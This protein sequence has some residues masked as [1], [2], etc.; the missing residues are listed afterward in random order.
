M[1][2]TILVGL[3]LAIFAVIMY[4]TYKVKV[5]H[6]FSIHFIPINNPTQVGKADIPRLGNPEAE[7][8]LQLNNLPALPDPGP[9]RLIDTAE[10][11]KVSEES[12]LHLLNLPPLPASRPEMTRKVQTRPKLVLELIHYPWQ[13]LGYEI[14]FMQSRPGFR[15]MTISDRRRIEIYMRSDDPP[16]ETAF[17]VAHELGHAFDLNY[18]NA[19]RRSRWCT[20]RGIDPDTPWFGCNRCPDYSTPAG[21]FAETFALLLLGPGS[22]HSRMAPAPKLEQVPELAAFCRIDL[23]GLWYESEMKEAKR[24]G[25]EPPTSEA[26]Q[27]AGA[28]R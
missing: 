8:S 22:Y 4:P 2:R 24:Q 20:M 23:K 5:E 11:P 17:D 16:L 10:A 12:S 25:P 18:N 26:P 27:T 9:L 21:D 1:R 7:S 28:P 19:E 3:L 14:V 6:A 15:A 13:Q